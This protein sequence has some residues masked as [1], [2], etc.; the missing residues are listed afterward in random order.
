MSRITA[1]NEGLF[2]GRN[3]GRND[4]DA[5]RARIADWDARSVPGEGN[6]PCDRPPRGQGEPPPSTSA[7]LR[8]P[9]HF[10]VARLG[11]SQQVRPP[12]GH[13]PLAKAESTSIAPSA[14]GA[15][16]A[17]A[18]GGPRWTASTSTQFFQTV[19]ICDHRSDQVQALSD[20]MT[21]PT[22]LKGWWRRVTGPRQPSVHELA[23]NLAR[24]LLHELR[25]TPALG[26]P[27]QT[28]DALSER[29]VRHSFDALDEVGRGRW[30]ERVNG[31]VK[32]SFAAA[33]RY[34]EKLCGD[35]D[36]DCQHTSKIEAE[37]A[38]LMVLRRM[39]EVA[40]AKRG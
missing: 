30:T 37:I 18:V 21:A 15:G 25:N 1:F 17:A 9:M 39:K 6:D 34:Q 32:G 2:F 27:R 5:I 14:S 33:L 13:A 12:P 11:R 38:T 24:P 4:H 29:L 22:G 36:L 23:S 7:V 19:A 10:H 26:D 40:T 16:A 28:F 3:V 20:R 31:S 35:L 8:R